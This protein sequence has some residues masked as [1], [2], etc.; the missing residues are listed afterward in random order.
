MEIDDLTRL[1]PVIF[2]QHML[3]EHA[4]RGQ[5]G[6]WGIQPCTVASFLQC[7]PLSLFI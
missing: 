5:E 2:L 7:G 3:T 4:F 6:S 1:D